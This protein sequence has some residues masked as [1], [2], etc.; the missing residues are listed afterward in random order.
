VQPGGARAHLRRRG[1]QPRLAGEAQHALAAGADPALA[2]Q[3]R[4]HRAIALAHE[5][6]PLQIAADLGQQLRIRQRT[7]R[8][9]A[10][11][12]GTTLAEARRRRHCSSAADRDT[13]ATRQ[14]V[15]NAAAA[16]RS[17]RAPRRPKAPLLLQKRPQ[18]VDLKLQLADLAL[19]IQQTPIALRRR[20]RLQP[21]TTGLEELLPPAD[22][23]TR[24]P[25]RL[26][27]EHIQR[28]DEE[29]DGP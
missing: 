2:A 26:P 15:F 29:G 16:P 28:D 3:P 4:P 24:R 11:R 9:A 19:R 27:R 6:R 12:A 10:T 17:P 25:S 20:P 22:D 23:P 7:H 13:P 18:H 5:P 1:E 14:T 21:R 8:A